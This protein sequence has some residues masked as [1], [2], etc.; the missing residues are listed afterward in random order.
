MDVEYR[1]V[2]YLFYYEG[3]SINYICNKLLISK[4]LVKVRL[5]RARKE[6]KAI[7]ELD[8]E[9]K[10]YQQYFINKTSMKKVRIIDMILGGENNQ[11][12]SILLY[13]EDSSKV[14]SMV[15]TKEEAENMLIAMKGIDFPRPLTFNLITEIIRTNHLIPEGAFITEVLNGILISTL[16]LKNELG[17]KNY[18]SRPSDAITIALMFNCPIYVSQNVQDKVGF[19]V[20]EKYKNIKPQEKGIDHLTQ[21]IENSLSDMETKL[22]SLKAKKSVNDMQEQIDR[23]MNYVFGAA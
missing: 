21:L 20:P 16:R 23:L 12:C 22:A 18:D 10:G 11:S 15:I 14:L 9:F 13:E 5:H 17:I 2:V 1:E 4:P 7:L 19:P 6:L 8:S 3:K